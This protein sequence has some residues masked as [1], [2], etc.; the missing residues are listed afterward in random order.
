MKVHEY[1]AKQ[2]LSR[3]GVP[4]PGG[5]VAATA[6]EA[7]AIAAELGVPVAVKAQIPAGGLVR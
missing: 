1:Q 3:Y 2:L 7:A 6:D 4:V 5:R